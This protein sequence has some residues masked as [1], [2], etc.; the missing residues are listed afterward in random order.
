MMKTMLELVTSQRTTSVLIGDDAPAALGELWRPAWRDA[1]IIG[2]E[3]TL[4][5]FGEPIA[6]ALRARCDTVLSLSFPP[7]EPH[8]TRQTKARLED[9]LL[10]AGLHRDACVVGLG[11]GIALDVAG[12]VAATTLRGLVHVNVATSLLAMIDAAVGGKTGVNTPHGKNLVG[13]FHQP[14]AV[15]LDRGALA[16]LPTRELRCGWAEGIKHAWI[17]DATLFAALERWAGEADRNGDD[18]TALLPPQPILERCVAI[19]A[20]V[21]RQDEQEGGLRRVLN[22]GHTVAHALETASEHALN[23]GEAVAIGLLVEGQLAVGRGTLAAAALER[24]ERLLAALGLPTR[25]DVRFEQLRPALARDKKNRGQQ[26]HCA[27][28]AALG[29]MDPGDGGWSSAV[30]EAEL[31]AAW[32]AVGC[33]AAR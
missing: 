1:A 32:G 23:H 8:K 29:R 27:L 17:A 21:V 10:S 11:G 13:A 22:A 16:S 6:D 28:P 5:L 2:D 25:S 31:E 14:A 9:A 19:K 18:A 30:T 12:F 33:G 24:L 20:E 7:G 3:T 15:L 4:G 26:I